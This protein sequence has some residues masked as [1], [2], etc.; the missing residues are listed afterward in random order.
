M[1]KDKGF[2]LVEVLVSIAV[3]AIISLIT[4]PIVIGLINRSEKEAFKSS[5]NGII[6]SVKID[7]SDDNFYAPRKY[8]YQKSGLTLL[9]V[10]AKKRD[11]QIDIIGEI[12]GAGFV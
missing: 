1:K 10:N 7:Y 8:F 3:I 4:T 5:V 6:Q 11:E 9:T 12:N 2:T